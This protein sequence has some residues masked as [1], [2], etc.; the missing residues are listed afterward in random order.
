M[1]FKYL[2]IIFNIIIVFFLC[3]IA[4]L[5]LLLV[6]TEF[7]V[8]FWKSAWPLA[9]VLVLFL[10]ILN[11]IFMLNYRLL[12]LIE[13]ED[14]PA[15]AY[16]LEQKVFIKNQYSPRKVRLL[17]NSYLVMCDFPS[18]FK[19][20]S[21]LSTVKPSL[22]ADNVLVFGSAR[23]LNG[24][25][26]KAVYLFRTCLEKGKIKEEQWARWFLG[27]SQMLSGAFDEAELE[28][29]VLAASSG[30]ALIAGLSAYFLV[31]VL[32]KRS[33]KQAEILEISNSSRD[34]VKNTLKD[35]A[36]WKKEAD[37]AGTEVH[38]AIV[39]KYIDEAGTWLFGEN[40]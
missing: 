31:T 34:R 39:R 23:I 12:M 18:V 36:D 14:W 16:Y 32:A 1:K 28:F 6:G 13:R 10:G 37:K 9:L 4:I 20:E 26:K 5:P 19:L 7:S 21:K 29:K 33:F 17:A 8:N 40:L 22:I 35:V 15:L 24:E 25:H 11:V 38:T 30:D 3:V 2:I 27:F